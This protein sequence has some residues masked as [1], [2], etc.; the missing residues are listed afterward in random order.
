M[1]YLLNVIY[2]IALLLA[3]PWLIWAAIRRGKYREG[4]S[5]KLLGAVPCGH[6]SSISGV[7]LWLHAVSVGEVNL[8]APLLRE[9]QRH[10]PDWELFVSTTTAAGFALARRKYSGLPVFYAPLDFSWA[11]RRAMG[12]FGRRCWY[13][14]SWSYGRI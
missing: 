1:S 7:R 10:H 4:W 3:S 5:E 9:I 6:R 8:I 12:A 11:V 14:Q 2:V 13:S